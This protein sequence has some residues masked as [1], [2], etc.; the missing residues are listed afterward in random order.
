M[1]P[2][3][4]G[5]RRRRALLCTALLALT[6]AC[7]G[8]QGTA[9]ADVAARRDAMNSEA[10]AT[11]TRVQPRRHRAGAQQPEGAAT[12]A[13]AQ[14]PAPSVET[15]SPARALADILAAAETAVRDENVRGNALAEAGH[16]QQRTYRRLS[17]ESR[18]RDEVVRSVPRRLRPAVRRNL[19]AGAALAS[20]V[21]PQRRL[22]DWRIVPPAPATDLLAHY[23]RAAAE[24]GVDWHYLAA[25]HLV[26]TRMGRIRGRSSAGARG[27]MQFMP[28]TWAAYGAGDINDNG[29]AIMAAARYLAAHGAPRDMHR[30]LWNYNHSDRYV[31]AVSAYAAVM[32]DDERAFRGYYHWQVYYMTADGDVQ[33]PVGYGS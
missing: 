26:E 29:D 32:R 2:I 33:L 1:V 15:V 30:A 27:P 6:P 16:T 28:A 21:G 10:A 9:P 7:S 19:R 12:S 22:P 20:L 14:A 23:R 18:W 11:G 31:E 5:R 3:S 4:E 17:L 8:D 13:P 25:I 24:Y